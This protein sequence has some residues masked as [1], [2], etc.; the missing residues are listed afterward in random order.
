MVEE[1]HGPAPIQGGNFVQ[2]EGVRGDLREGEPGQIQICLHDVQRDARPE[3]LCPTR[4]R[5]PKKPDSRPPLFQVLC[6][7]RKP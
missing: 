3:R 2:A 6:S 5:G 7:W 1:Q 4:S